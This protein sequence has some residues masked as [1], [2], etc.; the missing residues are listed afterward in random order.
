VPKK[1]HSGKKISRESRGIRQAMPGVSKVLVV[2]SR[3]SPICSLIC[4]ARANYR[5]G[6]IVMSAEV[7]VRKAVPSKHVSQQGFQQDPPG[8]AYRIL[9]W[10]LLTTSPTLAMNQIIG[11]DP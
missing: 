10:L 11:N 4:H 8:D 7:S 9:P 6:Y 2:G 1:A 3:W 5:T